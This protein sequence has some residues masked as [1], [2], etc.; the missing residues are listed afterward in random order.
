MEKQNLYFDKFAMI[1]EKVK[2]LIFLGYGLISI[3][4]GLIM[5]TPQEI[6]SGLFKIITEPDLLISD[7]IG[8][9]GL[10]AS[11]VNSGLLTVIC[12][13]LLY[14]L[15]TPVNGIAIAA[16]FLVAGFAFLGKNIFNIWIII[17]GV[18]A[19]A[20]YQGDSFKEYIYVALLS[21]SLSPLATYFIFTLD[22]PLIIRII[23]GLFVG[24]GIGFIMPPFASYLLR[25]HQGFNLYN[26]GFTA[27][28][29]GTVF[30]SVMRSYGFE[31]STRF[32]W[33]TGNNFVL[34]LYLFVVFSS[35]IIIGFFLNKR[36]FKGLLAIYDYAGRLV[37]DFII[38]E[39]FAPSLINM[40]I[41][42]LAATS[43]VLLVKGQL[44]GASLAGILTIAGFG[45]FGK[46]LKNIVPIF[47]GVI[48]GGLTKMWSINDPAAILAGLFGTTLAPIGGKFGWHYGILAGFIHSSVVHNVGYLHGGFNLYNNGFAGGIVAATLIPIIEHFREE[49]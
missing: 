21:T 4:F 27:G 26:V 22:Q 41:N 11:F 29:F 39:G 13:L 46:H 6:L 37:S 20:R 44:N 17:L 42:G 19:Y 48:L 40:G 49:G 24:F 15:R 23:A 34:S 1:P 16:I 5:D 10:G 3:V 31:I 2:F 32:V 7:Y 38:L 35:M 25:V 18:F 30:V 12:I 33:S 47:V 36:S 28:V 14:W 8:V 43:Y 9:G 45:A